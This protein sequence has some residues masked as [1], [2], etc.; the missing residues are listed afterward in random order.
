MDG[1][2]PTPVLEVRDRLGRRTRTGSVRLEARDT[3][4]RWVPVDSVAIGPDGLAA[5]NRHG[6]PRAVNADGAVELRYSGGGLEPVTG[7]LHHKQDAELRLEAASLNGQSLGPANRT[8]RLRPGERIAGRLRFRYSAYWAAAAVVLT[9]VA[10][11]EAPDSGYASVL[12]VATPME[13]GVLR[14]SINLAGPRAPGRY[15]LVFAFAAETD[16]KWI[17]SGTNWLMGEPTW[18]DGNDLAGIGQAELAQAAAD[19]RIAWEWQFDGWRELR[20]L[21]LAAIEVV[22]E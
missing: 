13:H 3:A 2:V 21:P 11:W 15:H 17:A 5:F 16:G 6:L 12:A 8:L 20:A 4:G 22:V 19:G 10:T 7:L 18:G 14:P 1:L 9:S